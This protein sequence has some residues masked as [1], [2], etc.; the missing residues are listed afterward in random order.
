MTKVTGMR[1]INDDG[2]RAAAGFKG[3]AGDCAARSIAIVTGKPYS[4]VYAAINALGTTERIGKRKRGKSNARTGVYGKTA[5]KYM[6]SLGWKWTPTMSIGSGCKVHLRADELPA[7]K[8]MVFV[9]RHF[10]AVVD[11]IIYDTHDCSRDGNRC[12]YG[13]F[14]Q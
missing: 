2:G 3:K 1:W 5:R 6:Q 14:S 12:V 8:L 7:G 13:Y 9:S 10:T 4:E 11:G